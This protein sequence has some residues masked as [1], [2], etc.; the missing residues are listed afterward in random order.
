MANKLFLIGINQYEHQT[1]LSS[2]IKDITDFKNIMLDK[3]DFEENNVYELKDE[4]AT[5]KNIQDAFRGY[6]TSLNSDDNLIVFFS[7]HG[8]YEEQHSRG[9]WIPFEAKEYTQFISN[10]TILD[11]IDRVKC[12]HL[13][14]ISDSCFSNSLLSTGQTKSTNEYFE[15]QSR[16]ALTSAF[17]E[18]RDADANTNT[19]FAE[20]IIEALSDTAKDIR[21][22]EVIEKVKNRFEINEFQTPQGAPLSLKDHPGRDRT[23]LKKL[24]YSAIP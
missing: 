20:A 17:Y 19:L 11:L 6:S 9:Y 3:F 14:L 21:F 8:E 18:A 10:T 5:S 1:A 12:K 13:I 2:C 7:G 4:R 16:W 23:L 24:N 15:K 22:S